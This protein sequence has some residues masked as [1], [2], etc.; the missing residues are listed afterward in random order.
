MSRH[1]SLGMD[2]ATCCL[3]SVFVQMEVAAYPSTCVH[4]VTQKLCYLTVA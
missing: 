3:L 2:T 4:W 1:S